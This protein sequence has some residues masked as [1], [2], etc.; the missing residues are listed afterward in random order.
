MTLFGISVATLLACL[1]ALAFLGAGIVNASG[2]AAIRSDFERWGYPRGW[3]LVTGGL[4]VLVAGLIAIPAARVGG[5]IL[6]AAICIVAIVTVVRLSDYG[7][8]APSIV[9]TA[10]SVLNVALLVG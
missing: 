2:S 4:E 5:L 10:L 3:N 8:L 6:G 1:L 9:L 7:H